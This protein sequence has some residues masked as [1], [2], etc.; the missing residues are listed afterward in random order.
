MMRVLT[1]AAGTMLFLPLV[2]I[3]FSPNLLHQHLTRRELSPFPQYSQCS[4]NNHGPRK[5]VKMKMSTSE[6]KSDENEIIACRIGVEGDVGGYYRSCVLNE[7]GK[8]RRLNGFMTPP[9]DTKQAEI[10]VE[11][12]R[13]MVDGFV[14]WAKRGNVGLSQIVEVTDV[15]YEA[16]TGLYDGFYAKTK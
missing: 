13:K 15:S 16:V 6:E 10:Y 4:S 7:A 9:N 5:L 1:I 2:T 12:K 14:R 8:F 11:G 3:S